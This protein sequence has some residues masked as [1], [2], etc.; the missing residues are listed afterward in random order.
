[1][2][3][4][5]E[6]VHQEQPTS[7]LVR[8]NEVGHRVQEARKAARLSQ[9]EFGKLLAQATGRSVPYSQAYVS[10]L[11][12]GK[13]EI[14]VELF[15]AISSVLRRPSSYFRGDQLDSD[16]T[17]SAPYIFRQWKKA[18]GLPEYF[19]RLRPLSEDELEPDK[20]FYNRPEQD[21]LIE[22][23]GDRASAPLVAVL[24]S[25]GHGC[26]TLCSYIHKKT[27]RESVRRRLIPVQ[28]NL[29]ELN[30]DAKIATDRSPARPLGILEETMRREIVRCLVD[31]PWE[32]VLGNRPYA[33]LIGAGGFAYTSAGEFDYIRVQE[34]LRMLRAAVGEA[35]EVPNWD[36]VR[37]LSDKLAL[38][39]DSLL[40]ELSQTY[41]IRISLQVDMSS[42][43][44]YEDEDKYE[45]MALTLARAMKALYER[46][47]RQ[48]PTLP[49]VLNE[50]YLLSP[51]AYELLN[52]T[53]ARSYE[54]VEFPWYRQVD[55]FA[56]LSYHYAPRTKSGVQRSNALSA[57]IDSALL[58]GIVGSGVPLMETIKLFEQR[59]L[60]L[61]TRWEDIRHHLTPE[62]SG[63]PR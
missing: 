13:A 10:D 58:E 56:I 63:P 20:T 8:V 60:K 59:L 32:R 2:S 17:A 31:D 23:I 37:H 14:S 40:A 29:D 55:V 61:M 52:A 39:I 46:D 30:I 19:P 54:V 26:S 38:G 24:I 42:K 41:Q 49:A 18:F 25:R 57:V 3:I 53:W 5:G 4:G 34:H 16:R 45:V 11:E 43:V 48:P 28:F 21:R 15:E 62:A 9:R 47:A 44:L 27:R 50:M 33:A 7:P 12:G 6:S 1:M 36:E 35:G 51:E 22:E